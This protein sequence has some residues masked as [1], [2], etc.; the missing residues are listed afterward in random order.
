MGQ[1]YG[2]DPRAEEKPYFH[3]R[4]IAS[5]GVG[6]VCEARA[7]VAC[8]EPSASTLE[9]QVPTRHRCPGFTELGAC[10]LHQD[11]TPGW[12]QESGHSQIRPLSLSRT[13]IDHG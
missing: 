8:V 13:R 4:Q 12:N 1:F 3:Y 10:P 6:A 5:C 9:E 7:Q 2:E 11:I